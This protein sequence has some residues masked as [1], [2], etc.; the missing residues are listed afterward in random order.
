MDEIAV[1]SVL[2][3]GRLPIDDRGEFTAEQHKASSD[4]LAQELESTTD[5]A[6]SLWNQLNEVRAY[7]LTAAP[8][9]P[10][11][12]EG[13]PR[14]GAEPTGPGDEAGWQRWTATLA[15]VTS[16]LVGPKGN[17]RYAEQEAVREQ[18][19]RRMP[20]DATRDLAPDGTVPE[21]S[22]P[23]AGE[24][25]HSAKHRADGAQDAGAT[26]P[27]GGG[28]AGLFRPIPIAAA[29]FGFA[30]GWAGRRPTD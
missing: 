11:M 17:L 15:A 3:A 18:H 19:D 7:L 29:V 14:T 30:L 1:P 13:M 2:N 16:L 26:A 23:E 24:P 27:A 6:R 10:R 5:Y 25:D 28:T 9:N 22:R 8:Q 12:I 4:A 20:A 21:Q